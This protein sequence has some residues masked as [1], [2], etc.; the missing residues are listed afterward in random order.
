ML[1]H[2]LNPVA[3][4]LRVSSRL[5]LTLFSAAHVHSSAQGFDLDRSNPVRCI[6]RRQDCVFETPT[7]DFFFIPEGI[8]LEVCCNWTL[9]MWW[10]WFGFF[11]PS[12]L[13]FVFFFFFFFYEACLDWVLELTLLICWKL[14]SFL[15]PMKKNYVHTCNIVMMSVWSIAKL[16]HRPLLRDHV[17]EITVMFCMTDDYPVVH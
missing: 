6:G 7:K 3:H 8:E 12:F 13:S 17:S 5:D 14:G 16:S 10:K 1:G 15:T 2:Q 9:L 4:P 11:F